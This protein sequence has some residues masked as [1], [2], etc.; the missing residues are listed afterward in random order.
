MN[1]EKLK[2]KALKELEKIKDL[3]ELE[4]AR[5]KHLGRSSE[6]NQFLRTLKDLAED[7]RRELGAAANELRRDLENEFEKRKGEL[8]DAAHRATDLFDITQPAR[9]LPHGHL[10]PL[11]KA[12][13]DIMAIFAG[14]GFRVLE[15][16]EVETEF[17]NFDAL[18]IPSDH[19]ARDLQDTF[20][21]RTP[22]TDGQRLLLRTHTSPMQIRFM[23]THEPPF[24]ILVPGRVF[25]NEATDMRHE[26]QFHQVEGLVV[27]RQSAAHPIS[28][29]NL[30]GV[31]EHFFRQFFRDDVEVRFNASYFA[32]TEP[33]VEVYIKGKK[34][35]LA[36]RWM[37]VAGAGMVHQNV[38][39]AVGYIPGEFQGFAFGVAIERLAMLKYKVDD[40]RL[41]H[42][43]DI[44]FLE[45]MH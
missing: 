44:R 27:D 36:G 4:L 9:K 10:N 43:G 24:R 39:K 28:L 21:L 15:G 14:M 17:N 6:L 12:Q 23:Q 26:W 37:E 7:G 5:V 41:F 8:T 40:I 25:R 16:P 3:A 19:P 29:A 31:L 2:Q 18:N 30:K 35:K 34:G 1:L 38:F 11:T 45:Q 33:S 20:W 42:S 32:F 13:E 22:T